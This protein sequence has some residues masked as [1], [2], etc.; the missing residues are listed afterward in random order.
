MGKRLSSRLAAVAKYV[1]HGQAMAD[2]GTDHA[3]LP[4]FLL[5]EGVVPNAVALDVAEGPFLTAQHASRGMVDRISVR[6]S[7]GL[8]GLKNNEVSTI[9]I[10]GMGGNT[11][12]EILRRGKP[13]WTKA[14]RLVLQP[15][16]MATSVRQVVVDSGWDCVDGELVM[17]RGKLFI[18]EVWQPV[19]VAPRWSALDYRWG[20][21]TRS[22]PDPLFG[23][24]LTRELAD[25]ELALSR[26][27]ESG[28]IDCSAAEQAQQE[29]RTILSEMQRME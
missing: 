5:R 8:D 18:V 17:D 25:V 12:A 9:C 22:L 21:R 1:L 16:G 6:R 3:Q 19:V 26:M 2:V 14:K 13:V 29:R 10:C 28:A 24:W 27:S 23:T 7:D 4:L 20:R 11:M 15:Q